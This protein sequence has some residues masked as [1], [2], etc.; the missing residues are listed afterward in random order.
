[1]RIEF[2]PRSSPVCHPSPL[3]SY[4]DSCTG[5]NSLTNTH[6]PDRS[7]PQRLHLPLFPFS[8]SHL[9]LGLTPLH[10]PPAL[11]PAHRTVP[12]AS[13][14]L[15]TLLTVVPADPL[16]LPY[17]LPLSPHFLPSHSPPP[18]PPPPCRPLLC[19][20]NPSPP[21]PAPPSPPSLS[22][23][24]SSGQPSSTS[25]SSRPS[26]SSSSSFPSDS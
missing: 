13:L 25:A 1:M 26:S 20:L 9:V 19:G 22:S 6:T 21:A 23:A 4:K 12:S 11:L 18:C 17:F 14:S 10:P 16:L 3:L 7:L 15:S 5:S 2:A 8:T 24:P